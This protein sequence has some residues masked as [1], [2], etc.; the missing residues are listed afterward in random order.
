[1]VLDNRFPTYYIWFV[2]TTKLTAK[3]S[4]AKLAALA[5]EYGWA[6]TVRGTVLTITKPISGKDELV[7][8]DMEYGSILG[9]LP[10]TSAGSVWGTDCGGIGAMS[11]L[12]TGLFKMNKSG[13]SKR[14]LNALKK[15]EGT[16]R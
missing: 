12:S 7:T 14:V 11:A 1:L 15:L 13:G 16:N 5:R 6:F 8:A 10:S 9:C 4:A 3:E 2:G